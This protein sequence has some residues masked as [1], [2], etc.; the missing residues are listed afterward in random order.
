MGNANRWRRFG[1]PVPAGGSKKEDGSPDYGLFGPGSIVWKVALHPS[2]IVFQSV[3]QWGL[4]L[5]YKPVTAGVRDQDPLARKV[6]QGKLTAFDY[7]ERLQRNSGIHAPMWFGDTATAE[8]IW[9]HLYRIHSHVEGGVIDVGEPGLGGFSATGSREVMWAA[10][11]EMVGMLWVYEHFA[12]HGDTPPSRLSDEERDQYISE[13][14]AYLRLVGSP[15]DEIPHTMAEADALFDK[16]QDL[17]KKSETADIMPDTG[18][19]FAQLMHEQ[20]KNN[21]HPTQQKVIDLLNEFFNE[22]MPAVIASY[23]EKIQLW[24][25]GWGEAQRAEGVKK[26]AGSQKRIR[27]MQE[28]PETFQRALDVFWGP[29]GTELINVARELDEKV[30]VAL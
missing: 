8:G 26:L 28:S 14:A 17:F 6:R 12:W 30:R 18:Q 1:V 23:P 25:A 27:Q 20:I 7:F 22:P 13:S 2:N 16:Y 5:M 19:H 9:K 29:D 4:Q 3:A 15:E 11:T 24:G 21:W 10:L